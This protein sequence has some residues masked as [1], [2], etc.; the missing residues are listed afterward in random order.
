MQ[1]GLVIKSTGSW[2]TVRLENG[3]YLDCRLKG[4]FRIKDV[5]TTNPVAVG[6]RVMVDEQSAVI[7]ELEERKNYIIRKSVNLSRQAQIIAANLDQA[8]LLV[9]LSNPTTSTGFIDRFLLTAE[10]YHIPVKIVFN[11][12]DIYTEDEKKRLEILKKL[13]TKIGYECHAISAL[14]SDDVAK[15]K[16]LL[17]DKVTLLSGHSGVGK[18]TLLNAIVP[19]ANATVG[20]T[21]DF[22]QKGKHTTTFAEMFELDF[23]GYIIDTPGIKGFGIVD[24]DKA[25]LSHYFIEMREL[26]KACKFNNCTHINEPNCAVL[27]ALQEARLE[28]SRYKSY[29]SIYFDDEDE[30]YRTPDY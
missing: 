18:S 28:E 11:K 25:E 6:D 17:K 10:A 30:T 2:Y 26:L 22:H 13:Y 24:L 14:N 27:K 12:V 4:K 19:Q 29:L 9:T 15:V 3:V 1:K 8:L 20:K 5:R 21:S 23:G 7:E 16:T